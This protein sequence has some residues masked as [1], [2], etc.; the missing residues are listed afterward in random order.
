[1]TSTQINLS[2]RGWTVHAARTAK[3]RS[4]G[5]YMTLKT[6]LIIALGL[7]TTIIVSLIGAGYLM[8]STSR[9]YTDMLVSD[10]LR[11]VT[12]LKN[13]ADAYAVA[14][15]DNV[16]KARAGTVSWDEA[17]KVLADA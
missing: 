17:V 12:N 8:L 10:H 15:V 3:N 1:M 4:G 6:R 2:S 7:L 14:I 11:P 16:H 5:R 9:G 13:V